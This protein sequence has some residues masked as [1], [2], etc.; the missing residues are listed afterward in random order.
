VKNPRPLSILYIIILA[1]HIVLKT[2]TFSQ[3]DLDSTLKCFEAYYN[4]YSGLAAF[5]Q[6]NRK[7]TQGLK[8][9][10]LEFGRAL[11]RSS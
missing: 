4:S 1:R 9:L 2:N 8:Q 7:N 6:V 11:S 3:Q 5:V 10:Y